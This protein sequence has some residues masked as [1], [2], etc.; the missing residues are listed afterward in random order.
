MVLRLLLLFLSI[1]TFR[2]VHAQGRMDYTSYHET[3]IP[4]E[5]WIANEEFDQAIVGYQTLIK[6]YG[7]LL[8]RDAFNACQIAAALGHPKTDSLYYY[9]ALAGVPE[10]VLKHN[11]KTATARMDDIDHY[12]ALYKSGNAKYLARIDVNLRNEFIDRFNREQ[13]AKG[14][15]S[16]KDIVTDNFNR[17]RQLALQGKFPGEQTIGVDN[18]LEVSYVMATLLHY[19]Y[20][21]KLL[22]REIE[23]GIR[24]GEIQPLSAL[25]LYGF[26][27]TRT[28][29]LYDRT[30][31][32][33]DDYFNL[34][35][36]LPFGKFDS[37]TEAVDANRAKKWV[38]SLKVHSDIERVAKQYHIDYKLGY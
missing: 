26:N 12:D 27:Q 36:N 22:E 31:P 1:L 2:S 38:P 29:V 32:N 37:N 5:Q 7:R 24:H 25:Y 35:Y 13:Q 10:A 9:C 15:P 4:V 11:P 6:I 28:S 34:S 21:Y 23:T 33:E 18:N 3:M 20:S 16:Y 8:A 19:P 30:V 14:Q 17:I